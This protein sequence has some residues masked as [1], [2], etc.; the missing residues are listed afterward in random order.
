[1]T[2]NIERR[3]APHALRAVLLGGAAVLSTTAVHAQIGPQTPPAAPPSS[4]QPGTMQLAQSQLAPAQ[5]G[6]A[7]SEIVVLGR[8]PLAE[9]QEAALLVQAASPSVVSVLSADAIGRLPDQNIAFAVGRL[10]GISLER[11]QGQAR[12]VNLRGTPIYWNTVSFDGLSVV[13]PEGRATRYDNIPSVLAR[14]VIVTKAIT[15]D[16]P[17]DTVAGNVDI[18]TRSAFDYE[19]FTAFGS[20]GLGYVT[21]GGGEEVDASLVAANRF[22][23]GKLGVMVQG[24]YYRRNMVTDNWE[25]DPYVART[26]ADVAAGVRFAR[27]YENKPYR[28]TRMNQSMSFR[29]DYDIA[30]EHAVFLQ[31]LW[32][33]YADEEL[34]NNYIF[35]FD[36]GR[37]SANVATG[38]RG[39]GGVAGNTPQAGVVYA[40][41][42]RPNT[43]SLGSEEDSYITT[44]GGKSVVAGWDID[45]RLN[46]TFTSDGRDAPALPDFRSPA[47]S[48]LRPTVEYDFSNGNDNTVRLYR[49]LV[50][51]V[52]TTT[53]LS[54]GERVFSI[55]NFQWPLRVLSRRDG[56]DITQAWTYKAD[57]SKELSAFDAPVVVKAGMLYVD[58]AKKSRESFWTTGDL[59]SSAN[60]AT[61]AR[62]VAAGYSTATF[63]D[64]FRNRKGYQGDYPLGYAFT[65]HTK[66]ILDELTAGLVRSGV[67]TRDLNTERDA[68]YDVRERVLGGY[69]MATFGRDWGSVVVG[70][71]GESIKNA[72][73]ALPVI[74][75]VRTFTTVE[76]DETL[77]YPSAHINWDVTDQWKV[78]LGLTSTASRPDFDDLRPNFSIDD[79][80]QTIVGGN[81]FAKPEKQ[82][83][84]DLYT[85]Y[86]PDGDGFF[87]AGLFYKDITDVLFTQRTAFGSDALDSG[88]FDR[89]GYD[90]TR[91]DNAGDGYLAGFEVYYSATAQ[92]LVE[93]QKWPSWLGG[94]GFSASGT[95]VDSQ[96]DIPQVI[97]PRTGL[98]TNPAR[99][100]KLLGA[101]DFT[102]NLA[103]TYEKYD[104]S[105][106]LAYQYRTPWGQ[107][108]GSYV[109]V[110]GAIVPAGTDSANGDT[111]W[112]ADDELDLSIRYIVNDAFEVYV[113]GINLL[114][115][116]GRRY[117]DRSEYPIE[118]EGFGQRYVAGVRFNF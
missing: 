52:G 95:W 6:E 57:V 65:Y 92:A 79:I 42:L 19:N 37:N 39:T 31:S 9:S 111:F 109:T 50:S 117:V 46:Y 21:L 55:D 22:F 11:D 73:T 72:S 34:R 86:Y 38:V 118:R 32:T 97:S 70:L 74:R 28:L 56:G 45:W 20:A 103:L 10:P 102:G 43:N 17:G 108:Y 104:L 71:R 89:T 26:P 4:T 61:L 101:S 78:R 88:G 112:D 1:M 98:V 7:T 59:T 44:L 5:A 96:V 49:T 63:Y 15:A 110:A 47:D 2:H 48:A 41:Q 82:K 90:Y 91:I 80:N 106:R 25:T 68:Y 35:R 16:M 99:R 53:T 62:F 14:Q 18:Q 33:Q 105:V 81:P 75:G 113:D 77:W 12:Y 87:S 94:W 29:L 93:R 54:R 13:S 100:Q 85:E 115:G 27:E 3:A 24:S 66:S 23:G 67:L 116:K 114:D 84:V 107:S 51:T 76:G 83:G 69:A 30:P 60:A 40:V 64:L 58:R 8:R 36:Q